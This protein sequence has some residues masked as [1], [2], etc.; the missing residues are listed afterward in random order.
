MRLAN[1]T[2]K[3][4]QGKYKVNFFV[5]CTRPENSLF[6]FCR[7]GLL[8]HSAEQG[9]GSHQRRNLGATRCDIHGTV[10]G[11]PLLLSLQVPADI[12]RQ[13]LSDHGDAR[14]SDIPNM[15]ITLEFKTS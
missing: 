15:Y 9:V 14:Q 3:Q 5:I 2:W 8:Q 12:R 6:S 10:D 11:V 7:T 1:P 13:V 4:V